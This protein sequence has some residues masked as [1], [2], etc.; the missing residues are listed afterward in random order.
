MSLHRSDKRTHL[1][2]FRVALLAI[3]TLAMTPNVI[4]QPVHRVEEKL[5][6][7]R[8]EA[9]A[10]KYYDSLTAM[11]TIIAPDDNRSRPFSVSLELTPIPRLSEEQRTVGFNGT[12]EEDLNKL[13]VLA[14]PSVTF[15]LPDRFSMTGAWI[16]PVRVRGVKTNLFSAGITRV[17]EDSDS[18]IAAATVSG[19]TGT[20]NAAITCPADFAEYSDAGCQAPSSDTATLRHVGLELFGGRRLSTLGHPTLHASAAA[21]YADLQFQVN[22]QTFGFIDRRH[23]TTHGIIWNAATGLSWSVG[24]GTDFG[25]EVFYAPLSVRRPNESTTHDSLVT[26]RVMLRRQL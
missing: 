11:P 12:K 13:G 2:D 26:A 4:A 1:S 6:F 16:P 24:H 18:S 17:L 7:D 5:S 8:P 9:W 19:Q 20:I 10:L 23:E 15:A 25:F 14:R 22:A 21:N 3:L